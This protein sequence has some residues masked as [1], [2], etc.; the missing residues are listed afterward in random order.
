MLNQIII[1]CDPVLSGNVWF[2]T[3]VWWSWPPLSIL[4]S[5]FPKYY[6]LKPNKKEHQPVLICPSLLK[7]LLWRPENK[8][9]PCYTR[10]I[11]LPCYISKMTDSMQTIALYWKYFRL[12]AE[13][14]FQNI[15][16]KCS[17]L[18]DIEKN[19]FSR[20]PPLISHPLLVL[21]PST[22]LDHILTTRKFSPFFPNVLLKI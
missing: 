13:S 11:A 18:A 16:L 21:L 6:F 2:C 5:N 20:P 12:M 1:M 7:S 3:F 14:I 19:W 8:W 4:V 22:I 9:S 17:P 10:S 15:L